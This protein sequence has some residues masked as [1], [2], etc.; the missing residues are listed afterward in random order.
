MPL[1]SPSRSVARRI[2]LLSLPTAVIIGML[3]AA[4]P[5]L[6]YNSEEHQLIVDRGVALVTM[7]ASVK[8]PA[9]VSLAPLTKAAYQDMIR[10]AKRLAVG[11][12]SNNEND[13]S[14]SKGA[15][16][17]NCYWK[18]PANPA[19]R[20]YVQLEE[21]KAIRVPD[22]SIVPDKVLRI[23]GYANAT[24]TPFTL[25]QLAALYGDY[26]R[27]THCEGGKCFLTNADVATVSFQGNVVRKGTYCPANMPTGQ[28]LQ[29][30]GSGL[31]PPY[32]PGANQ[33][34][35]AVDNDGDWDQAGWY[36]DEM[37][38]NANINDWHFSNGAIAW[39]TGLHRLAL[40]YADS[41]RIDPM[42]WVR[43]LHYEAN[44]LHS[45]TDLFAFG[46]VV[47]N[48]DETAHGIRKDRG[49]L[50][51]TGIKWM[52]H[53]L[54]LGGATR[55]ETGQLSLSSNL[56][57]ITNAA[58]ERSD[59]VAA[60]RGSWGAR[61]LGERGYHKE[62]NASGAEVR[63]LNGDDFQI[64]GDAKLNQMTVT[65]KSLDVLTQAVRASVQS[66]FDAHDALTK[67]STSVETL[68]KGGSPYFAALKFVPVYI[69]SDAN[70]YFTGRWTRYAKA[71][72]EL[73]GAGIVP[74]GWEPC[75]IP[76][77]SGA[78]WTWPAKT[79][80]PCTAFQAAQ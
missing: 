5:M 30:I 74:S 44:A 27:T 56:P 10:S 64:F 6:R 40:L 52:A 63:N 67:G 23:N 45:L 69:A 54:T 11:F 68:G 71:V 35:N 2:L 79:K 34:R 43:A 28:Y 1:P 51:N 29:A 50:D 58:T 76:Y 61:A 60:N 9:G 78:D 55:S 42:H 25:G 80:T 75:A 38:R 20:K 24:A 13:Y 77:L 47:T 46:H 70:S 19:A 36:G 4:T 53:V 48:R 39:Y 72:D 49:L 41:A 59:F 33:I 7:P 3:I 17:D 65:G 14:E 22:L 12:D 57:A 66:L 31:I 8:L 32:L 21:N 62:M 26:R 37:I 18:A 15:V 73:T 16:Q